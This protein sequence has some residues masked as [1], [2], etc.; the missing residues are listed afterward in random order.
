MCPV[1]GCAKCLKDGISI[2][3]PGTQ[4]EVQRHRHGAAHE[5]AP[6]AAAHTHAGRVETVARSRM[7]RLLRVNARLGE[8]RLR[9]SLPFCN[10]SRVTVACDV[11]RLANERTEWV[12]DAG[13]VTLGW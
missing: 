6:Q 7:A 2:E 12:G 3:L 11:I 13:L 4:T 8:L 9:R 10:G 1:A 5:E